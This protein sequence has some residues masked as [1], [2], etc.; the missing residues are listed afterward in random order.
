MRLSSH[1]NHSLGTRSPAAIRLIDWL[2]AGGAKSEVLPPGSLMAS[3][4]TIASLK[5]FRQAPSPN[6]NTQIGVAPDG[7]PIFS[8]DIGTQEVYALTLGWP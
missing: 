7:S 8:R 6:G 4:K 3:S 1:H 5:D 2:I